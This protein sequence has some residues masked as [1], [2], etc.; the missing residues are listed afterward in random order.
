MPAAVTTK[1]PAP[2]PAPKRVSL[3]NVTRGPLVRPMRIMLYGV[4]GVGKSSWASHAPA[5]IYLGAEE[6]TSQLD[7]TRF[8]DPTSWTETLEAVDE[9]ARTEHPYKTLVL[10][11]L[12]SLEALCWAHVCATRRTKS[13]KR[14][15][16]IADFGFGDGYAVALDVWRT[17]VSGLEQ[18]H[19]RGMHLITIAHCHV[20]RTNNPEGDD[21]DRYM[22]KLHDKAAGLFKGWSDVMLFAAY[23]TF[24]RTTEG[25]RTKGISSGARV[26]YT[27]YSAAYDAK[28]RYDLPPRLPLDWESFM[29]AVAAHRPADPAALRERIDQLLG[30][31]GATV[32]L[33]TRVRAAVAGAGDNAAQ[34]ARILNHLTAT[35]AADG[36]A[37][38]TPPPPDTKETPTP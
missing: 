1:D 28:N 5:P 15:E 24:T 9:L 32:E 7:V 25:G 23:E 17:L 8:P 34:L 4:P 2:A 38:T 10:D 37:A 16:S 31:P 20:K 14:A 33:V 18:V 12:D 13:G 6:G 30:H 27:E 29:Q 21:F 3:A 36:G 11:T 35:V 22:P 19:A 26:L